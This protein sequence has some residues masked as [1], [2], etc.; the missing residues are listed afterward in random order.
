MTSRGIILGM[1]IAVGWG[2]TTSCSQPQRTNDA[3][4]ETKPR[5]VVVAGTP[6]EGAGA[7]VSAGLAIEITHALQ[8]VPDLVVRP[9][10]VG[11]LRETMSPA[12]TARRYDAGYVLTLAVDRSDDQWSARYELVEAGQE[13]AVASGEETV[14]HAGLPELPGRVASAVVG[15]IL[16]GGSRSTTESAEVARDP[17]AYA[18]F[19]SVLGEYAESGSSTAHLTDRVE[20]LES[21]FP[22]LQSYV[23]AVTTLGEAYLELAGRVGGTGP[24]Y[25]RAGDALERAFELDP[26]YPPARSKLASYLAK[27]GRSEESARLAWEGLRLH[28]GFTEYH[29]RLGYVLRYA[30]H[31]D[32]SMAAYRRSQTLDGVL[33][34]LVSSQDQITKSYIYQGEYALALVSH[35]T[36]LGHLGELSRPPDEKQ[37]FYEG[38]IHL[39]AGAYDRALDAFEASARVDSESVWT[40]FGSGYAAIARGDVDAVLEV[41]ERLEER[42]VVDGERHYRLVHLAAAAGLPERAVEHLHQS[43]RSGFFNAPYI[44]TDP[45]T[46]LLRSLPGFQDALTAAQR[47]HAAFPSEAGGGRR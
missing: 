16:P 47:R 33:E 7:A 9:P 45:L 6:G 31:M 5:L 27:L 40:T 19:L 12:E 2:T 11:T 18:S 23:P 24:Y 4:A 3:D 44:A 20:A 43:V 10:V 39:Y 26:N 37:H 22:K 38:V 28:P 36:M 29:E 14:G 21:L 1:A 35:E 8:T 32:E 13:H 42:E 30:G 41:L 34:H 25:E 17:D 46:S 15:E